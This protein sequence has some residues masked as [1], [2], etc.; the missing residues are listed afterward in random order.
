MISGILLSLFIHCF[1]QHCFH[2]EQHC[3]LLE[4]TFFNVLQTLKTDWVEYSTQSSI[5][6]QKYCSID[7]PV[8]CH[9]SCTRV[10]SQLSSLTI[11]YFIL[12]VKLGSPT[13]LI[14]V[15]ANCGTLSHQ[16]LFCILHF[17]PFLN[18]CILLAM[19]IVCLLSLP[20]LAIHIS[21]LLSRHISR[22]RYCDCLG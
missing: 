3:F 8:L 4:Q 11:I 13:F 21:E 12:S 9:P 15:Y 19:C 16:S 1:L 7:Y 5:V 2:S 17:Y 20:F 6:I 22:G 10:L 18:K 14:A